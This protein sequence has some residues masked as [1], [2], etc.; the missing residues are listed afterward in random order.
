[1][2]RSVIELK[3]LRGSFERTVQD[4]LAQ[5]REYLDRCGADEGHL[6]IFDRSPGKSWE[7]KLS[8]REEEYKGQRIEVWGM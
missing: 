1:V 2:Q 8:H 5:T 6:L 7:E 3:L 4:G